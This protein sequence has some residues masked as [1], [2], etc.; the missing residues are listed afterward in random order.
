MVVLLP[1]AVA[2][3]PA[4]AHII[5]LEAEGWRVAFGGGAHTLTGAYSAGPGLRLHIWVLWLGRTGQ[6]LPGAGQYLPSRDGQVR[7]SHLASYKGKLSKPLASGSFRPGLMLD[8][9]GRKGLHCK[10]CYWLS[11]TSQSGSQLGSAALPSGR[12]PT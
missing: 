1:V 6:E 9:R 2:A 8:E 10:A 11:V 7:A 12:N 5:E 4:R 3:S